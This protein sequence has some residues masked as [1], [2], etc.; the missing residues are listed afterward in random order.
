M[1]KFLQKYKLLL[2]VVF[3]FSFCIPIS[4]KAVDLK[5]FCF[6]FEGRSLSNECVELLDENRG[7]ELFFKMGTSEIDCPE[8]YTSKGNSYI[9]KNFLGGY[10][11]TI[12]ENITDQRCYSFGDNLR[13]FQQIDYDL[14]D[15]SEKNTWQWK[16]SRVKGEKVNKLWGDIIISVLKNNAES[17]CCVPNGAWSGTTSGSA[18]CHTPE[19]DDKVA[20]TFQI[21]P[22]PVEKYLLDLNKDLTTKLVG[23]DSSWGGY[24][25]GTTGRTPLEVQI[26]K[27]EDG[28]QYWNWG[29]N[30]MAPNS[31]PSR[32]DQFT[33]EK[34][35]A[36]LSVGNQSLI[37]SSYCIRETEDM[38]EYCICLKTNNS[39]CN[40][41]IHGKERC[42]AQI[43]QIAT[44]KEK[45]ECASCP[46][47]KINQVSAPTVDTNR[48]GVPPGYN[49]PLPECAFSG[50]CRDVNK[51][52]ELAINIGEW[53]FK[54]I[55]S[56]GFVFFIYGGFSMVISFGNAEK[57]KKG[58]QILVAAIIGMIIAFGA[59]AIVKFLL[60]SLGV[61]ESWT[62]LIFK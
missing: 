36:G 9:N 32:K 38:T 26:G 44:G 59:Y 43:N 21:A 54:I 20:E 50:T 51:L 11:V 25:C 40:G 31:F 53:L 42:E 39:D 60:E 48:Y 41:P 49:G 27:S 18:V 1:K 8:D 35:E 55:G 16:L 33:V 34:G 14:P 23:P 57:F 28:W 46:V 12:Q 30:E 6:Y 56:L 17:K 3:V 45:Y 5:Y 24:K 2:L 47:I 29:C 4:V 58:R 61:Q 15:H 37:N 19:V 52:L 7:D 22:T 62:N 10:E 13:R